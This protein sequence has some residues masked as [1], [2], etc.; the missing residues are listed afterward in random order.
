MIEIKRLDGTAGRRHL[1]SLASILVDCVDGG[2][3]VSFMAG[4]TQ[5]EAEEF[6]SDVLH[7]MDSGN[8]VLFGAFV[9]GA[10]A[11]TV[12]LIVKM[13]PNQPHRAEV[14]K[15]LVSRSARG[16]GIGTKLM[17]AVEQYARE[18]GKTLLVLDT[19]TGSDAE[20]LYERLGWTKVGVIPKYALMP[21]GSWDDTTIFWKRL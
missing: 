12:Q 17:Q 15:L 19:A 10:L 16:H 5:A 21:D 4:F 2:A 20:R 13:P 6:F 18:I 14:S 1:S 3:S 8:R 7:E 11:G 9:D